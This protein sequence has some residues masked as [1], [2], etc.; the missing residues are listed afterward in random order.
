MENKIVKSVS[1]LVVQPPEQD[2]DRSA[3]SGARRWRV[4]VSYSHH[5]FINDHERD[6]FLQEL[7][8]GKKIIKVGEMVL[9]SKFLAITKVR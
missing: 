9:T 5:V 7:A 4:D 8:R 6:Y 1:N 2:T 3:W